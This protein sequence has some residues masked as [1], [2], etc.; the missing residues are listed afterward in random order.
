MLVRAN[1]R[2][3]ALARGN[4]RI[5]CGDFRSV[6]LEE[7]FY[8]VVLACAVLHH[9]RD[10]EDWEFAFKKIFSILKKRRKPLDYRSCGS[11]NFGR[12]KYDAGQIWRIP[13]KNRRR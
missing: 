8:D 4:V 3:G 12:S 1:K 11:F 10:D 9:L 13:V 5:F 2:V 7:N 6:K